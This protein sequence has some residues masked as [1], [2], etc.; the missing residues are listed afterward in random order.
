MQTVQ[1]KITEEFRRLTEDEAGLEFVTD[2]RGTFGI[3]YVMDGL[4]T[5]MIISY[6]FTDS[7]FGV[8]LEGQAVERPDVDFFVARGLSPEEGWPTWG[9]RVEGFDHP[10]AVSMEAG[11]RDGE[12]LRRMLGVVRDLLAAYAKNSAAQAPQDP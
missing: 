8:N 11:F 6:G 1:D 3:W 5:R 4:D 2:P 12:R 10:R 9:V 7:L